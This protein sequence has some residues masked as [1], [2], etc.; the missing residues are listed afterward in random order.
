MS[1][2]A[3]MLADIEREARVTGDGTGRPRLHTDVMEAMARVP[4]D[5]FVPPEMADQA[6]ADSP[7][8]IGHGQTISQPFIVALMTDLLEPAADHRVL[9]VGTGC[10]Y[11]AAVL[12]ELVAAVH[13]IEAV[14]PLGAAASERLDD[15]GYTNVHVHIGNG[16][17]GWA[18]AA[19]FDGII[20]TAGADEIPRAWLDQ[21]TPGGHLVVPVGSGFRGQE[22]VRLTRRS[23]GTSTRE[24]ILPVAFVPLTR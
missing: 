11:Q 17:L 8:P 20:V 5:A 22:L 18:D 24:S 15:L 13:S 10:G 19:P 2:R 16:R 7:L 12:A 6:Y 3:Q 14:E 9:E 23:D 1:T 21:L 4:R